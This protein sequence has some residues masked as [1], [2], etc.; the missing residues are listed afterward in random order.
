L[1]DKELRIIK[2]IVMWADP[3]KLPRQYGVQVRKTKGTIRDLVAGLAKA[4][5]ST[6]DQLRVADV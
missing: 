6:P 2:A 1:P 5:G 3:A 4:C